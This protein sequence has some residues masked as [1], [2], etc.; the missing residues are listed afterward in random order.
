VRS[1]GL[2]AG[3]TTALVSNL[4]E[5]LAVELQQNPLQVPPVDPKLIR[6]C[7]PSFETYFSNY[8]RG[9]GVRDQGAQHIV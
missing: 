7:R 6:I 2:H 4:F 3:H 8:I 5:V 9:H 1:R